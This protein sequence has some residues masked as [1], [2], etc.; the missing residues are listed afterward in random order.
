MQPL[1]PI[2]I[3]VPRSGWRAISRAGTSNRQNATA[4]SFR[5]GGNCRG[6][7]YH[8]ISIGTATFMISDG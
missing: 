8:A 5:P 2:S 6:W 7:K 4:V 1:A 3:A